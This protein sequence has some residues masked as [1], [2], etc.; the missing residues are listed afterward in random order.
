[1]AKKEYIERETIINLVED[2]GR[3]CEIDR[4]GVKKEES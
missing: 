2:D 1:M 4:W 3:K